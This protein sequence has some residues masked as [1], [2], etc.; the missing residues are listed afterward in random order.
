MKCMECGAI[1]KKGLTA[2]VTFDYTKW[3]REYFD[4][5]APEEISKEASQF[6][7]AHPYIGNAQRL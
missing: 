3:H 1:A 6:E 7:K 2:S 5:K 4:A